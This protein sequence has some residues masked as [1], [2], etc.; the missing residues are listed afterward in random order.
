[1]SGDAEPIA[2][3][4]LA[5]GAGIDELNAAL[6]DHLKTE[7]YGLKFRTITLKGYV[8]VESDLLILPASAVTAIEA[9]AQ[10][11]GLRAEPTVAY[12]ADTLAHDNKVIP[13]PIVAGLKPGAAPPLG[14]FLPPGV[15]SLTDKE[16]VLLEWMGSPLNQL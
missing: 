4:L 11:L 1:A 10:D 16:A 5:A 8:S 14:P 13:Y 7:D 2:N 9:S 3:T 15:S 12:I 6:R